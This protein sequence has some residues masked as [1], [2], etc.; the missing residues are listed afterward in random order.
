MSDNAF[1]GLAD[2]PTPEQVA[3]ALGKH[4]ALWDELLGSL[5]GEFGLETSNWHSYSKKYGWS[6]R[7][8]RKERNI[9]YLAPVEQ[10][11]LAAFMLGD[12]AVAAARAS[13]LSKSALA[14]LDEA[15]R[16][17]EGT[18][19][20]IPVKKASDLAAVRKLVAAKLAH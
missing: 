11:F 3:E 7:V 12:K 17:V 1:I 9:V 2:P 16:Y 19:V 6:L 4:R 20:R 15:R 13:K 18:L 14:I 5:S 8:R 10:G